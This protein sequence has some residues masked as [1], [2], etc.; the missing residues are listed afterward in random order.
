MSKE[1]LVNADA[2]TSSA[3]NADPTLVEVQ[4]RVC[5]GEIP[6]L[7]VNISPTDKGSKTKLKRWSKWF[8][9]LGFVAVL[10]VRLSQL[11]I[12]S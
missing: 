9:G 5:G 11:K 4:V 12:G 6:N 10:A 8:G 2:I 3:A 7:Q 1:K